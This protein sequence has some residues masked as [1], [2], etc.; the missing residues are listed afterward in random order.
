MNKNGKG[1]TDQG[2]ERWK[3]KSSV[4]GLSIFGRVPPPPERETEKKRGQLVLL[5]CFYHGMEQPSDRLPKLWRSVFS[6]HSPGVSL[7]N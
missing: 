2:R 5:L 1:E 4:I 7:E 3:G 6:L